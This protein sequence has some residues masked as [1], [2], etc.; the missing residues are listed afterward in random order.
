M[1]I[2]KNPFDPHENAMLWELHEIRH[3]LP[4]CRHSLGSTTVSEEVMKTHKRRQLTGKMPALQ[5]I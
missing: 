4:L 1:E 5:K 2:Y 3:E